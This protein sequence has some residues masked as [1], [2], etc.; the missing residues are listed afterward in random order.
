MDGAD[1]DRWSAVAADWERL[2]D[3]FGE[4]VWNAI[5]E[6]HIQSLVDEFLQWRRRGIGHALL[7]EL[8]AE[9]PEK[10]AMLSSLPDTPARAVYERWG[11]RPV[12]STRPDSGLPPWH[13]LILPL[14][15]SK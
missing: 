9:R 15:T 12:A 3:G 8:L 10:Y 7:N 4:P 14:G 5:L 1:P 2:W 6:P 13:K 11:W